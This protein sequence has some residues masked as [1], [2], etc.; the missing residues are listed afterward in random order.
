[1]AKLTRFSKSCCIL[2][3]LSFFTGALQSVA[4]FTSTQYSSSAK[5]CTPIG[6][7]L[8][9]ALVTINTSYTIEHIEFGIVEGSINSGDFLINGIVPPVIERPPFQSAYLLSIVTGRNVDATNRTSITFDMYTMVNTTSGVAMPQ[10]TVTLQLPGIIIV[11]IIC[12]STVVCN[13]QLAGG[14][15]SFKAVET[16]QLYCILSF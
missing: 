16:K 4:V 6:T 5:L 10:A 7:V 13:S 15:I 9:Q 12:Y 11:Y 2:N 1:M 8:L 3:V 14:V